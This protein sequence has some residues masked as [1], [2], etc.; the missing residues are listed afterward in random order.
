MATILRGK[1]KGRSS[2]INQFC[3]DWFTLTR[4]HGVFSPTSLQLTP[5]EQR[6]YKEAVVCDEAGMMS[7][8]FEL[9]DDGT[10]VRRRKRHG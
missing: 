5:A 7:A 6:R 10:F 1:L 2:P 3:N 8:R 4:V 9:R